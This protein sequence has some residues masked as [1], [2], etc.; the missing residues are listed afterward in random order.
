MYLGCGADQE[1]ADAAQDWLG[2]WQEENG[3][4]AR[5]PLVPV[6]RAF[7]AEQLNGPVLRILPDEVYAKFCN[8][9]SRACAMDPVFRCSCLQACANRLL[10][11]LEAHAEDGEGNQADATAAKA[12]VW[13]VLMTLCDVGFH[14]CIV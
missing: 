7:F 13:R 5:A 14:L 1:G 4:D 12:L 3:G 8:T 6:T 9:L 2:Q 10:E 11:M